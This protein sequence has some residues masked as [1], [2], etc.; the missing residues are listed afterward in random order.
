LAQATAA[1]S[2]RLP[3]VILRITTAGRSARSAALLV[4]VEFFVP[5][6]SRQLLAMTHQ[7]LAQPFCIG[8]FLWR[9]KELIQPVFQP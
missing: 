8:M 1:D 5:Q 7:S 4:R 6:E 3:P 9:G 2:L